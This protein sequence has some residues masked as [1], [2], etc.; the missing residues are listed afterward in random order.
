PRSSNAMAAV[1]SCSF[2]MILHVIVWPAPDTSLR[3]ATPKELQRPCQGPACRPRT[4]APRSTEKPAP[5]PGAAVKITAPPSGVSAL[6]ADHRLDARDAPRQ[7][8]PLGGLD[9]GRAVLVGGRR[10]LGH[11]AQR[12]AADEDAA[13]GQLV[14]DRA[15]VV[16]ARGLVAAHAA[17]GAVA[18]RAEAARRPLGGAG[19]HE[20]RAAHAAADD[21][22]LAVPAVDL[23]HV[24]V[25]R[26]EGARRAL[27][28]H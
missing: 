24:R 1:R 10:L 12:R 22:G 4:G 28:V 17:P 26:A 5:A 8:R 14:D 23:G 3:P 25:A 15:A 20:A 27:A 9:H 6:D 2:P 21:H 16:A 19:E 11:A 18:G 7:A 13:R